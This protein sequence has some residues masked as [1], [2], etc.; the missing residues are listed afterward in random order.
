MRGRHGQ[1]YR[2]KN[3][4]D[5]SSLLYEPGSRRKCGPAA[6]DKFINLRLNANGI[7]RVDQTEVAKSSFI[8]ALQRIRCLLL[9]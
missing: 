4:A 6:Y 9:N 5:W 1:R 8:F 3:S 7:E 2:T